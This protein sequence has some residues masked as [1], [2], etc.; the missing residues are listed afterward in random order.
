MTNILR[1]CAVL[2]CLILAPLHSGQAQEQVPQTS[3][4]EAEAPQVLDYTEWAS[5]ASRA[6]DAIL[7]GR[8]SNLALEQ[9]QAELREWRTRFGAAQSANVTRIET[10]TEQL[11]ALGPVPAEGETEPEAIALRRAEL[12]AQRDDLRAP[13]LRAEEARSRADGL[14]GEIDVIIRTRQADELLQLGPS[15]LNVAH[16]P[17][18]IGALSDS[19]KLIFLESVEATNAPTF[20]QTLRGDLPAVV[21]YIALAAVLL[22]RGR[23]WMIDLTTSLSQNAGKR[24]GSVYAG[25]ISIGQI[26]LPLLGILALLEAL[27]A[28]GLIGLRG[29]RLVS[30]IPEA[31]VIVLFG[32]W[33]SGRLFPRVSRRAP[34]FTLSPERMAEARRETVGLALVAALWFLLVRLAEFDTYEAAEIAVLNFP[35]QVLG[36]VLLFRLG[37]ILLLHVRAEVDSDTP[38]PYRNSIIKQVARAA[39]GLAF[40]GPVLAAIGYFQASVFFTYPTIHS[41]ALLGLLVALQRFVFDTYAFLIGAEEDGGRDALMPV[42]IGFALFLAAVPVMA[43]IWGAREADLTELWTRFTEGFQ[44][45]DTRLSP[46]DFLIFAIIFAALYFLTRLFQGALRSTILPKTRIDKGGQNAIVS[47]VGYL[48]IFLAAIIAITATGIDLSSI[49]IVAGALSVGIG[50]GLQ[51]IVSNFVSGIILLIERPVTEGDWIEVGGIM[52]TVR[53]ISVRSTR[54]ETFDRTDVIVPN[55]DLISGM[56]TNFTRSNVTGRIILKVGV[57]YGTDTRKVHALLEE[58]AQSHPIVIVNPPPSVTFVGFGADSLDFEVRC[59]LSDIN[60]GLGVRSELNHEIA[61]RFA[62]EG[63]EIPFAQRD[64]WLRNPEALRGDVAAPAQPAPAQ[65][66]AEAPSLPS[67]YRE[68]P[69]GDVDR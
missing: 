8:A 24:G 15:P 50:F 60:F 7:A 16:W 63:I 68:N 5:V 47:G 56:V 55:T 18:A 4:I 65:A 30:D 25:V 35:L 17:G 3:T 31:G 38:H 59:V 28:A 49:A 14:I 23:R 54:V 27:E 57:A 11:A 22:A 53:D 2:I 58:I 32:M 43:L 6:E 69:E 34:I 40:V 36:G 10:L 66:P 33:L 48:G 62:Q 41:L 20:G 19:L 61:S 9:L 39:M 1:L 52:G 64:I 46:S 51:N 12:N 67:D 29:G 37:Q 42:L 26:V 13:V 44:L 45:G 21:F